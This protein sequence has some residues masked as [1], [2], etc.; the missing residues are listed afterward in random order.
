MT[1]HPQPEQQGNTHDPDHP[2]PTDD[3]DDEHLEH[4]ESTPGGK[5]GRDRGPSRAEDRRG[6][7]TVTSA[8]PEV[9]AREPDSSAGFGPEDAAPLPEGD[10]RRRRRSVAPSVGEEVQVDGDEDHVD[11]GPPAGTVV[12]GRFDALGEAVGAVPTGHDMYGVPVDAVV[13]EDDVAASHWDDRRWS[14]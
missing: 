7:P 2:R 3:V 6:R 12:P 13:P 9:Q 10:R 11:E 4:P 5:G 8:I 14:R 1:T